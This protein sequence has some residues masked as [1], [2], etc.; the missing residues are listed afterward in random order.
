MTSMSLELQLG[1][2]LCW[3]GAV[4]KCLDGTHPDG[5]RANHPDHTAA[6]WHTAPNATFLPYR[7][8][9]LFLTWKK[10]KKKG[11]YKQLIRVKGTL[12][13]N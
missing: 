1:Q 9:N 13:T 10:K 4:S 3:L 11:N 7:Y 8:A 6:P 12:H 2:T 5:P